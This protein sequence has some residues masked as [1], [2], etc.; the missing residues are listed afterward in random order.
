LPTHP[1]GGG[2]LGLFLLRLL[3]RVG[4]RGRLL[5]ARDGGAAE[6]HH[7]DRTR[8]EQMTSH[9]RLLRKSNASGAGSNASSAG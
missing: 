7:H 6:Q 9:G 8:S 2:L 3:L 4:R 1:A 5:R